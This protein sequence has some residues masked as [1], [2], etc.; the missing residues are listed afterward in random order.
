MKNMKHLLSLTALAVII[1]CSVNTKAQCV[2]CDS[3]VVEGL[4]SSAIGKNNTVTGDYSFVGGY[5]SNV[6]AKMSFAFG[7]ENNVTKMKS[8]AIGEGNTVS[9]AY[10]FAIGTDNKVDANT[11][12]AVGY[13]IKNTED[14]GITIGMGKT[15]S[16]PL[17]NNTNGIM[18]GMRSD[19]PTFF[20]SRSGDAGKTGKVGIGNVTDPQAKLHIRADSYSYGGED[21]DIL[22]EPTKSG[23]YAAVYFKSVD[24][25][26]RMQNTV[27]MD[28]KAERYN[29]KGGKMSLGNIS[30]NIPKANLHIYGNSGENANIFLQPTHKEG[31]AE[32]FFCRTSNKIFAGGDNIMNFSADGF[33]FNSGKVGIGCN[34]DVEGFSLAVKDGIITE[35][36]VIK[37]ET[38]WPD[39]VFGK[40]YNLMSLPE[41]KKFVAENKHLPDVPSEAE[42]NENGVSVGEMQSVLLQKIEEL[43]LYTIQQQEMI[44]QLK[45]EIEELKSK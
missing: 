20:I 43:T 11:S 41:L 24:N 22:L 31:I 16:H 10:S 9:D 3:C 18:M 23:N 44:D 8:C 40:D 25:Y 33:V 35:K 5:E 34:N 1:F 39:F 6:T 37:A 2:Q 28:F 17:V 4:F 21:A 12:V 14:Y 13:M 26:I 19:I 15:V 45:K 30:S 7:N 32:I 29:F 27:D 36:V 38:E 42:V